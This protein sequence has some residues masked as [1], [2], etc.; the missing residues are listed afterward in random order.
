MKE[1][2]EADTG[3]PQVAGMFMVAIGPK[4]SPS[5][6]SNGRFQIQE[7]PSAFRP[8]AQR[9]AFGRRDVRL[10]SRLFAPRNHGRA[11]TQAPCRNVNVET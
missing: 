7:T 1:K 11:Q 6:L 10:Q 5:F 9:N 2:G 3:A 4:A 8:H